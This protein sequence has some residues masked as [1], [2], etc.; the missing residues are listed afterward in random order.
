MHLPTAGNM[1]GAFDRGPEEQGHPRQKS[2]E[3]DRNVVPERL[4]VLKL[5]SEVALEIVLD[6]EDAEK[7]RVAAG[8]KDIPGKSSEAEGRDGGG[9]KEAEGIAPTFREKRPE[10]N[11]TAGK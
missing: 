9:M 10:E 6:D 4:D 11:S 1:D 2:N 5:G 3:Q 7:I 8:A